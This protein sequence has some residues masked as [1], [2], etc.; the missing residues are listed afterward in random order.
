MVVLHVF[1]CPECGIELCADPGCPS[2]PIEQWAAIHSEHHPL[3]M[4]AI[5]L[6]A[7]CARAG[8]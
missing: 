2:H 3:A 5:L 4:K 7:D 6:Y 8:G 1:T